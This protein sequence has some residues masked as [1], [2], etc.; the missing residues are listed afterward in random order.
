MLSMPNLTVTEVPRNGGIGDSGRMVQSR[1]SGARLTTMAMVYGSR[2]GR[3]QPSVVAL[4]DL[5]AV[6]EGHIDL[7]SPDVVGGAGNDVA[8]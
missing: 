6:N 5:L 8:V 2:L 4:V 7:R 3:A 1:A